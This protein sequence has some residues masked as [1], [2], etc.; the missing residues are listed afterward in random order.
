M[1]LAMSLAMTMFTLSLASA[2]FHGSDPSLVLT[3]SGPVKGLANA[4]WRSFR[5]IPFAAPPLGPLRW[6]PPAPPAKWTSPLDATDYK[7]NC[8]QTTSFDPAQPR[9]T[10]S[11][12]CLYLNVFTPPNATKSAKLPVMIWMHGGGY[13]GGGSNESRLNATYTSALTNDMVVVVTNYRLNVF[14]FAGAKALRSRDTAKGGTGNYGILDQRAALEWTQRNI[15]AFGGDPTRVMLAGE[16]AGGA[17]VHN[18]LVRK[19]SWGLFSRAVIESGGYTLVDPQPEPADM[20]SSFSQLMKNAKCDDADCLAKLD[21]D[22]LFKASNGVDFQPAV[23]G[24]DLD[25]QIVTLFQ[26]G[27]LA[28]DVPLLVGSVREDLG[29]M[30]D[31]MKCTGQGQGDCSEADFAAFATETA[32]EYGTSVFDAAKFQ[33]IYAKHEVKLPGGNFTKWFWAGKHAGSDASMICPARRT[34]MWLTAGTKSK[35]FVYNFAHAPNHVYPSGAFHSSEIP[36]VFHVLTAT[37]PNSDKY[38]LHGEVEI[39]LSAGMT[40]YW[41]N[42]ASSG[43]PNVHAKD[44][45]AG[46]ELALPNWPAYDHSTADA[47]MVFGQMDGTDDDGTPAMSPGVKREQ[48]DFW[49]GVYNWT[50]TGSSNS[51]SRKHAV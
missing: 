12:D 19:A 51:S 47:A 36:F 39:K 38:H 22:A 9:D 2:I 43:D 17:S 42:F 23:D 46:T 27:A 15:A 4:Q 7:H 14:G 25:D 48:C 33:E 24:V 49:D 41:R 13:Q 40:T 45:G 5:G 6:A 8:I 32:K 50:D 31:N 20:E 10:L 35:A 21:P 30:L 28:P 37:G 16:S 1:T 11:E 18:H 3:A 26:Q 34:A 29:F 44:G